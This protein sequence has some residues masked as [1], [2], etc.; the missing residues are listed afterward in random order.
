MLLPRTLSPAAAYLL[1]IFCTALWGSNAVVGRAVHDHL[2]P[3]GLAFW[4]NAAALTVLL[5][6]ARPPLLRQRQAI[7]REWRLLLIAGALG[8]SAFNA[9]F[10]GGVHTTTAINA[11]MVMALSPVAIPVFALFLLGERV[12]PVQIAGML[13][14]LAGVLVVMCRGDWDA[15]RAFA[16]VPGDLLIAAAMVCWSLYA[17][18]AKRRPPEMDPYLFLTAML[19]FGVS[20]LLPVYLLESALWIAYPFTLEAV[21]APIYLGVFPT[22]IALILFNRAVEVVGANKTG[23]FNHVTPVFAALWSI[24]FLDEGLMLFHLGGAVLILGGVWCASWSR[25]AA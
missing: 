12:T 11:T 4:R 8:I 9:L 1:L 5:I 19:A 3:V 10:Y 21:L 15:F 13:I 25:R 14:S 22:A 20:A 16:F 6:L 18:L 17:V 7:L 24:L 23:P 2:P